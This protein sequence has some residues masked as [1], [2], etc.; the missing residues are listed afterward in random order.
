MKQIFILRNLTSE[1]TRTR[2]ESY[3]KGYRM[4]LSQFPG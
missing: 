3:V 4:K 2:R 1:F